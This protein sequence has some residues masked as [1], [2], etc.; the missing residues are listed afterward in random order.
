MK[1]KSTKPGGSGQI[2][3]GILIGLALPVLGTAVILL[4]R[5][6]LKDIQSLQYDV[7]KQINV[8]IVTL[9]MIMNAALFFLFLRWGRELI[10]R[11]IVFA[12]VFLLVLIFIYRFLW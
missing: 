6:E 9:G 7:I 8:Q 10:S 4:V 12:S 2:L 3:L 1:E 11:G 5:P